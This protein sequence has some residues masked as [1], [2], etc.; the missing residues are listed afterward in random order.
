MSESAEASPRVYLAG[1]E[2]YHPRAAE[3]AANKISVCERYGLA[4][5]SALD[6]EGGRPHSGNADDALGHYRATLELI[7][8]CDA[9][10]ANMTPFRG[11]GLDAATALEM[12]VM[13]GY[14]RP[15]VGYSMEAQSYKDRL[16][17]LFQ[18]IE[19]ELV[20]K[21][22]ELTT[23]DGQSVEDFGLT[24]TAMTAGAALSAGAPIAGDF[25]AAVRWIRRL[26]RPA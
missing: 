21:G 19:E 18:E 17:N 22:S 4:G 3:I 11:P 5:V 23:R 16:A 15:I 24:D 20:K 14:G 9:L 13:A 10:I 26:L 2:I 7:A 8:G 25:E 6:I 12:G 1:P